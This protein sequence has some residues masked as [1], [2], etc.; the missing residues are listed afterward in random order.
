MKK[1]KVKYVKKPRETVHNIYISDATS[2]LVEKLNA[3]NEERKRL[4]Q[5]FFDFVNQ[6][7]LF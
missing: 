2:P 6:R 3:L 7:K 1:A 4:N 5:E